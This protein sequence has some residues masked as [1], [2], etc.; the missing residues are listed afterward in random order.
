MESFGKQDAGVLLQEQ[1][2]EKLS[3]SPYFSENKE[4]NVSFEDFMD[5]VEDKLS[6]TEKK[7]NE[8]K[9]DFLNRIKEEKKLF[10]E[11]IKDEKK[12]NAA[13]VMFDAQEYVNQFKF[14]LEEGD[15]PIKLKGSELQ[16]DVANFI[17]ENE[18]KE[19]VAELWRM[20]DKFFKL[21]GNETKILGEGMKSAILSMVGLKKILTKNYNAE[22]IFTDPNID[23][24]YSIDAVAIIKTK[25][26]EDGKAL[27]FQVKSLNGEKVSGVEWKKFNSNE[28]EWNTGFNEKENNFKKGCAKYIEERSDTFNKIGKE[29]ISAVF[30][31]LPIKYNGKT[32][33]D[34]D[35]EPHQ[36]LE[37]FIVEKIDSDNPNLVKINKDDIL[38]N[39]K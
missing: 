35:G 5:M 22:V 38:E 11:N 37:K 28:L 14:G 39:S 10:L 34:I 12:K 3:A 16:R 4:E 30:V 25:N 26:N 19:D 9:K 21:G 13:K 27:F 20:Y 7:D 23:V 6:E 33:V 15:L 24:F 1:T 36:A 2:E 17:F 18:N 29:N 8:T 32:S 31:R